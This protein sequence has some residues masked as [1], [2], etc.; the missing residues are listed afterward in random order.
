MADI[1]E[2]MRRNWHLPKAEKKDISWH[3]HG[4]IMEGGRGGMMFV[5]YSSR[6]AG[7]E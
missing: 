2:E 7:L 6:H 4:Y 5:Y 1:V 3:L